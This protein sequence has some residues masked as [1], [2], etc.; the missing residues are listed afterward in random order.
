MSIAQFVVLRHGTHFI[1]DIDI[2]VAFLV[3]EIIAV[4]LIQV[5]CVCHLN[6]RE[7]AIEIADIRA[8]T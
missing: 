4:T 8:K 3:E 6:Q 7:V 2:D 1:V 5:P